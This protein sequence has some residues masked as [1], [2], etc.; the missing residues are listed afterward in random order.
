MMSSN[1]RCTLEIKSRISVAKAAIYK[2]KKKKRKKKKKKLFARKLYLDLKKK[3]VKW[4]VWSIA[5]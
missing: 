1:G 2:K 3:L 5:F 4:Y